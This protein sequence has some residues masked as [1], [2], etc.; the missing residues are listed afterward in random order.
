MSHHR[1][2]SRTPRMSARHYVTV[3][4]GGAAMVGVGVLLASPPGVPGPVTAAVRSASVDAVVPLA[5]PGGDSCGTVIG[6]DSNSLIGLARRR[7]P[8]R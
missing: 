8:T 5:P 7:A 4:V 2:A 1:N 6:C 3:G